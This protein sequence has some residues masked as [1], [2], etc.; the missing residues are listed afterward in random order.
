MRTENI[1]VLPYDAKWKIHYE[2]IKEELEKVLY[3]LIVRIEHVGSTSVE[4]LSAKPII[5]ID[6]VIK[7]YSIVDSV[8]EKL[9]EIGYIHEGNLGIKDREAFKYDSKPHLLT[10]HIYVCPEYSNELKR[11]ITFRDYLRKDKI[12]REAYSQ[13]KI[14]AAILF[15]TQ[16]EKY[17]EYKTPIIEQIYKKCGLV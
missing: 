3:K 11:H 14:K 5:D 12:S 17:G 2:E 13:V 4:G 6:I 16:I 1:V 7:D 10:H 9:E 15:P 8:K